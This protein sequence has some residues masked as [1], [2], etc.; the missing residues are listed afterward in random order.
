MHLIAGAQ[1]GQKVK[2]EL[3]VTVNYL[4]CVLGTKLRFG[5]CPMSS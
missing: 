2:L 3:Q 5:K 4:T 1:G